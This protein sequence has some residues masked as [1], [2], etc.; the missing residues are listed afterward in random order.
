LSTAQVEDP[1]MPSPNA[2]AR[3]LKAW[4]ICLFLVVAAGC[5]GEEIRRPRR[6]ARDTQDPGQLL[7]RA[8]AAYRAGNDSLVVDFAVRLEGAG[9][10]PAHVRNLLA[11]V[12]ARA[13]RLDSALTAVKQA[14]DRDPDLAIAHNNLGALYALEERA[15]LAQVAFTQAARLD[16][17]FAEPHEGMAVVYLEQGRADLARVSLSKAESLRG[18]ASGIPRDLTVQSLDA[19]PQD[20]ADRIERLEPPPPAPALEDSGGVQ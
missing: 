7:E 16:P 3:A 20:L 17:D 8:E 4:S 11:L 1:G 10:E 2:Q 18:G 19:W 15:G 13:G 6:T 14:L 12:H 5:G 9:R